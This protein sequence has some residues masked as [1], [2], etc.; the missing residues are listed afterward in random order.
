MNL[1]VI[2]HGQ[3]N[4]NR[5]ELINSRNFI[6]LNKTGKNE[7]KAAIKDLKDIEIDL[8]F[9]S[10][11]RKTKQTCKIIN[12]NKIKVI[13][14]NRLLE[15]E[16]GSKHLKSASKLDISTWYDINKDIVYKNS[17]GFKSVFER[18]KDFLDEISKKYPN[19]NILLVTHGD[20]C[21]A[22]YAY[23]N[24]V[25]NA[26]IIDSSKQRNCEIRKYNI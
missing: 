24:N 3:T 20:V 15:R 13:Y 1:Y 9:C 11:L 8:I 25:T 5:M 18:T 10:P 26:E 19:K 12:T 23:F 14:D 22:I 6:G 7:A 17:E 2:R 21:K 16:A 4:V